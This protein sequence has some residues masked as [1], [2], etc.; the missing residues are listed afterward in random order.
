MDNEKKY[1]VN[2][3]QLMADWIPDLNLGLDPNLITSGSHTKALWRCHKCGR[4]W[5]A[6]VHNRVNGTGCT[7]DAR[8]RQAQKLR[9]RLVERDG[10]LQKTRPE[11]AAQ[12]HPTMNG[13]LTPNDITENSMYKAWWIGMDGVAWQSVVSVR[14]RTE[15]G[16]KRPKSL[17]VKGINDLKT[18]RPDLAAEWNY[19]RNQDVDIDTIMPGTKKKVWW[20]CPKGHE[21]QASVISRN[22]GRGCRVCNQE[23]STSFPEQVIF[24]YLKQQFPD[25]KNRYYPEEK[26]EIDIYLPSEKI[27]IEYDGSY[28]HSSERKKKIDIKKNNRLKE[29]GIALI[30]VIESGVE[31]PDGT[32][33]VI[34]CKRVN[35]NPLIDEATVKL[36][37]MLSCITGK[38]LIV[39]INS[40]RDR[41]HIMEQYILSEKENSLAVIKPDVIAEWHPTKNGKI[42]PEYVLAS[43][44]KQFWW[45]CKTCGHEWKAPAYRRTKGMGCPAC[46]GNVVI[47]GINDLSTT[48]ADLLGEWNY[49]K[50]VGINPRDYLAGSNKKVWWI[51][52]KCGYEWEAV[53][54]NRSRG[55]N[56]PKCAGKVVDS[57]RSFLT[58]YPEIAKEWAY[59]LNGDLRPENYLPGSD[60]HVW[61]RCEKGHCW[62]A[63]ISHRIRNNNCPYCGNKLLLCGYNDFATVYPD[64]LK[65]WDSD[66]EITP[67]QVLSGSNKKVKWI[68]SKGHKWEASISNRI[69]GRGCPYCNN[70]I[71][72]PGENDLQTLYPELASEW[73]S[74]KNGLLTPSDVTPGSNKKVW[75]KC[76][77]CNGEWDAIIWSRV[78]GRGCPFCAGKR[79]NKDIK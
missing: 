59:D 49:D 66:N 20:I 18:L 23:R 73:N 14:C 12:W 5:R 27:G 72:N 63:H 78:K 58:L 67:N 29:L 10:S 38:E 4:E 51:C 57:K 17:V 15:K 6:T 69:R 28:Y 19:D 61:W 40:E 32:E 31:A 37:Q 50:N 65:E 34:E 41:T 62:Q 64:M 43:S 7:C 74:E 53:I 26:L 2:F 39:D 16:T 54:S 36:F 70:R 21:W 45:K 44:N 75:W 30:R 76:K 25:A 46:S 52:K 24:Y 56:C 8:E 11:I 35:S 77:K 42:K 22:A 13:N 1:L 47:P 9:Q 60:V 33:Y 3:P 55:N 71:T 48:R 68:C 79:K